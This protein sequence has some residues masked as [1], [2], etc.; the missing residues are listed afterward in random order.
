MKQGRFL[1]GKKTVPERIKEKRDSYI[2]AL[3]AADG[4]W[5]EGRYDVTQL[6]VYLEGLLKEQLSE[7]NASDHPTPEQPS[8]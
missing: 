4:A 6:A 3:Q 7:A 5:V 8:N 1:P 2:A